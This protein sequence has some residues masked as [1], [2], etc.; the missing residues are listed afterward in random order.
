MKRTGPA[1][2]RFNGNEN[3]PIRTSLWDLIQELSAMTKDDNLVI[4]AME[5]VFAIHRVRIGP[6]LAPVRLVSSDSP[7][8]AS[9]KV[10]RG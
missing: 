6:G 4:A 9:L 5:S 7:S 2:Q 1:S 10:R 3:I 8:K